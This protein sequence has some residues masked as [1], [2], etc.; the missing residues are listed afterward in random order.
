M[1]DA[2]DAQL[3]RAERI[4]RPNRDLCLS[5]WSYVDRIGIGRHIH[6]GAEMVRGARSVRDRARRNKRAAVASIDISAWV[7][8]RSYR[9]P[10]KGTLCA[11]RKTD[12]AIVQR[13]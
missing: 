8:A 1:V 6:Y 11:Q 2:G 9:K 12:I 5:G 10:G 7:E 4:V 3:L 13:C